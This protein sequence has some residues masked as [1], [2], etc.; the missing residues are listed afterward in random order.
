MA[1]FAGFMT[2]DRDALFHSEGGF[3]ELDGQVFAQIGAALDPAAA[4]PAASEDIAKA[5]ELAED[6]A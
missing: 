2:A 6:F 3:F 5:E 4:A 1:F